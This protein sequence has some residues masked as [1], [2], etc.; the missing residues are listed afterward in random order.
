MINCFWEKENFTVHFR[1]QN[2]MKGVMDEVTILKLIVVEH[3]LIIVTYQSNLT[4]SDFIGR[5][6]FAHVR[7]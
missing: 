4:I 6:I 3:F 7:C 2:S 5:P 1:F